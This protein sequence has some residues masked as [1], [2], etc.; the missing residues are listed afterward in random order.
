VFAPAEV[1]IDERHEVST[2][3]SDDGL[4]MITVVGSFARPEGV[5]GGAVAIEFG[6]A[7]GDPFAEAFAGVGEVAV[8]AERCRA[9]LVGVVGAEVR[10]QLGADEQHQRPNQMKGP[11]GLW[12]TAKDYHA[13]AMVKWAAATTNELQGII[14]PEAAKAIRQAARHKATKPK[15]AR[16]QQLLPEAISPIPCPVVEGLP[17]ALYEQLLARP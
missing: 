16:Y 15:R 14:E 12:V 3:V 11:M 5:P 8:P 9:V 10:A 6:A 1:L 4:G 13:L 17:F 7:G 2:A